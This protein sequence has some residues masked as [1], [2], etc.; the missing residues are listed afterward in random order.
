MPETTKHYDLSYTQNRELSWLKFNGRVLEEASDPTVPLMER[1]RFIS[2]FTSNLDE[3][4]MVR[5]GSLFDLSIMTPKE[6]EN[7][8]GRTPKEQLECI[9]SAVRPLIATRDTVYHD[10][11]QQLVE[12]GVRDVPYES[13]AGAEKSAIQQYYKDNIRPLLSPP[14]EKSR[15]SS[16]GPD[17]KE[18]QG[19]SRPDHPSRIMS[20]AV[21]GKSC[22]HDLSVP[23]RDPGMGG[24]LSERGKTA[25]A[26]SR[27]GGPTSGRG[28][29]QGNTELSCPALAG[30]AGPKRT[31]SLLCLP[32]LRRA[33]SGFRRA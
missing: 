7:K 22:D 19:R 8:S 20:P 3:F 4:F 5:V 33:A 1:L 13:L 25:A 15:R 28:K 30:T 16:P 27:H 14:G 6:V 10:L 23:L 9:Y 11:N 2:I 24:A 31:F 17:Q 18:G 12:K 21:R 26:L 29:S 32:C